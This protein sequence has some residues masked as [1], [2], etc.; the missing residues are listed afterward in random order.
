MFRRIAAA[1]IA[2]VMLSACTPSK[3]YEGSKSEGVFFTVPN[4]WNKVDGN[5]LAKEEAKS[6][7]QNDIDRLAMVGYQAGFSKLKKLTARDVFMLQPTTEPVLYVRIRDLFPEERNAIS[8]NTLRNIILPVTE[9]ADGTRA[10]DRNFQLIDDQE[11][12]EK[13]GHGVL[14][15]YSFDYE[16]TNETVKQ[17][18]LY[19]NDQN[20]IYLFVLRCSTSCFNKN[21]KSVDEI[22]KSFTVRGT[23]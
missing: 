21:I 8:L 3:Q 19:S 7:N 5:E 13:G 6:A 2:L 10:N 20:K 16:G 23:K 18:A 14:L 9:Y 22:V 11:V 15:E 17:A 4:G 1:T 12:V